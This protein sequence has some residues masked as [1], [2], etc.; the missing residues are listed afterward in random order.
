MPKN[1]GGLEPVVFFF[2]ERGACD[3]DDDAWRRGVRQRE[4]TSA[5]GGQTVARC[6][7]RRP[8]KGFPNAPLRTFIDGSSSRRT[9]R[10]DATRKRSR[11]RSASGALPRGKIGS[12]EIARTVP[13]SGDLEGLLI[14]PLLLR[15][16]LQLQERVAASG[17]HRGCASGDARTKVAPTSDRTLF[18]RRSDRRRSLSVQINE[19]MRTAT[20]KLEKRDECGTLATPASAR[21]EPDAR[22]FPCTAWTLVSGVRGATRG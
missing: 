13:G 20:R 17:R 15:L 6:V 2:A 21:Q 3:D 19:S 11:S 12:A 1:L 18:I 4:G 9:S 5:N 22:D 7:P 14:G 8:V 16:G 10:T